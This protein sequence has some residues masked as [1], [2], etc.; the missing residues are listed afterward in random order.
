MYTDTILSM[1]KPLIFKQGLFFDIRNRKDI[2]KG[3]K[4]CYNFLITKDYYG[5]I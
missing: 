2:A 1:N 4:K 3:V 5:F